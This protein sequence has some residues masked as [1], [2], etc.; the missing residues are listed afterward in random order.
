MTALPVSP[1]ATAVAV[2]LRKIVRQTYGERTFTVRLLRFHN[3]TG[4]ESR[5]PLR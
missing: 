3:K 5:R 1:D 2:A 4:A